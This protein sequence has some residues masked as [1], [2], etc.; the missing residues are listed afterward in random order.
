MTTVVVLRHGETTWNRE[1]RIQGWAPTTLNE[2]GREQAD[3]VGSLLAREFDVDAIHSSDL[4]RCRETVDGLRSHLDAPVSFDTAWRERDFGVYQG[5]RYEDVFDRFPQF[6]LGEE[7]V[8][9]AEEVPD[10]GE[11]LLQVRT[12]VLRRWDELLAAAG[13]D[14][15][16]LVVTHG[17]PIYMILGRVKDLNIASAVLDHSQ[18]NCALNVFEYEDQA[19]QPNILQENATDWRP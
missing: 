17:G 10:S 19:G 13:P 5:L 2:R 15:T 8:Q 4:L 12:R 16:Q 6:G 18:D 14:E 9:A 3:A 11:S 1:R 7:A